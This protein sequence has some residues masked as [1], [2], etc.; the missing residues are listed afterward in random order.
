MKMISKGTVK[1]FTRV[2][3]L[4][5]THSSVYSQCTYTFIADTADYV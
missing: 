4:G 3:P 2:T 1:G 5:I